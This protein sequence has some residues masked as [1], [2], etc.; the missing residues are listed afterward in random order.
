MQSMQDC[1][2]QIQ[3]LNVIFLYMRSKQLRDKIFYPNHQD[4]HLNVKIIIFFSIHWP[5]LG[6]ALPWEQP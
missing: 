3:N 6:A 2:Q 4:D 5:C 1:T